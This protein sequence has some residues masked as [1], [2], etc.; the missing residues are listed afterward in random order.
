MTSPAAATPTST[1]ENPSFLHDELIQ[2]GVPQREASRI[3]VRASLQQVMEASFD[4]CLGQVWLCA[5]LLILVGMF[6]VLLWSQAVYAAHSQDKCD[7]PLALML[8]LIFVIAILQGLQRD[9][10]RNCLCYDTARDGPIEPFRVRLFRR[11]S[12]FSAFVWPIVATVML[13]RTKTCNSELVLATRVIIAYYC[14]LAFV[15]V[16][17]PLFFITVMMCL[18]R[19]GLIRLPRSSAAAPENLIE[20][21]PEVA[22]DPA[23]FNDDG[24]TAPYPSSCPV[25]LEAF[26][27]DR[28]IKRT[29]CSH[30][31]HTDCLGGW[32]QVARSCPLCRLDLTSEGEIPMGPTTRAGEPQV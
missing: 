28:S 31:F 9:I 3:A 12:V 20:Q 1:A 13:I 21:L 14:V 6:A 25:C 22:Y 30:V 4:R 19:R 32:L 24:G 27:A 11:L 26:S 8:R 29:S 2:R 5:T 7:Q 18:V 17:A 10:V 23:L 15:L 16:I